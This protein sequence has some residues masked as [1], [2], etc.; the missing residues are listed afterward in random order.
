[1]KKNIIFPVIAMVIV[2]IAIIC[3][4]EFKKKTE[5]EIPDVVCWGDSLTKGLNCEGMEYPTI[6][7]ELIYERLIVEAED[8][9]KTVKNALNVALSDFDVANEGISGDNTLN[10]MARAG[11]IKL[12]VQKQITFEAGQ[13]EAL[14]KFA[15]E[16]GMAV[17]PWTYGTADSG[18]I[19]VGGITGYMWYNDFEESQCFVR[20]DESEAA[21][22][23]AGE[24]M[25]INS[26]EAYKDD[27]HVVFMGQNGSFSDNND[28]IYQIKS[29]IPQEIYK[30]GRY[31]VIGLSSGSAEERK[32]MESA[33]FE[34]FGERFINSRE[35][36][37]GERVY[38][39]VADLSSED[40]AF[41]EQGMIPQALRIKDDFVHL[42]GEGY[43]MLANVVCE[44]MFE[45]G[46]YDEVI[47]KLN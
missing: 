44:R 39:F 13:K 32:E 46:F 5:I 7:E 29:I 42:N 10:I 15:G 9:S 28:L 4:G 22:I 17:N 8:S 38:E 20:Y 19:T 14:I 12:V 18:D 45:L 3:Y 2:I 30:S 41:M 47:D 35:I 31:L 27:I 21:V 33:L 36:L 11:A 1:M 23:K 37:S 25:Q 34:E 43:N 6:L 40:V 26:L 24:I 16:N